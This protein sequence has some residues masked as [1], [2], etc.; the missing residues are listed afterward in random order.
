MS[1][2]RNWDVRRPAM[3]P[4]LEASWGDTSEERRRKDIEAHL[5]EQGVSII[6]CEIEKGRIVAVSVHGGRHWAPVDPADHLG[7]ERAIGRALAAEGIAAP[8]APVSGDI[9]P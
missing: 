3:P 8:P 6:D 7:L 5:L 2:I 4:W 9:T 1:E